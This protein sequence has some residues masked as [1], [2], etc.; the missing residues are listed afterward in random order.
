[1][2]D[3]WAERSVQIQIRR[4]ISSGI[5]FLRC[6]LVL[7]MLLLAWSH[8]T[9]QLSEQQRLYQTALFEMEAKGNYQKAIGQFKRIIESGT[10][11]RTLTARAYLQIGKCHERLGNR[12][13]MKSYEVI[14]SR[15]PEQRETATEARV[16][17][18]ELKRRMSA[19]QP[20]GLVMRR[21]EP[22]ENFQLQSAPSPDGSRITTWRRTSDTSAVFGLYDLNTQEAH[23]LIHY[24]K[25][26]IAWIVWA[27]DGRNIAFSRFIKPMNREESLLN[28]TT[29]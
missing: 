16:R 8:C 20:Y 17:L 2:C 10:S 23:D 9:A 14:L 12:E 3:F 18:N 11:D 29:C 15:Y 25:T 24:S 19:Q 4:S 21:I 22:S 1:M 7:I 13:A 5:V 6:R 26:S 27:P 28:H